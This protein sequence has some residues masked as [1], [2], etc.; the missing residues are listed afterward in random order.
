MINLVLITGEPGAGKTTLSRFFSNA[1]FPV[2]HT[3]AIFKMALLKKLIPPPQSG[4]KFAPEEADEFIVSAIHKML[5]KVAAEGQHQLIVETFPRTIEQF[6][7]LSELIPGSFKADG[8][9][10]TPT[11]IF[12]KAG[13]QLREERMQDRSDDRKK[14][15]K[16]RGFNDVENERLFELLE[17]LLH[18]GTL[19]S[20]TANCDKALNG[21]NLLIYDTE[22]LRPEAILKRVAA[23][24]NLRVE[25][26]AGAMNSA[27]NGYYE[28][29]GYIGKVDCDRMIDRVI[30]ECE[31]LREEI[32][33]SGAQSKESHFE[34]ADIMHFI[35]CLADGLGIAPDHFLESFQQKT[36][37]NQARL[38]FN[39]SA[40]N[41][42]KIIS[43]DLLNGGISND[44]QRS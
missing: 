29:S 16:D 39:V 10:V 1:G 28:R 36:E 19:K 13:S 42:H 2:V 41:K 9:E 7:K 24:L 22:T 30:E 35:F 14:F 37:I 6:R 15:D 32:K 5:T 33:K 17:G 43:G 4:N 18:D 31:E 40:E 21:A 26:L 44:E 27:T 8:I 12:L 25:K 11:L 34:F 20:C 23:F 38:H 3:S